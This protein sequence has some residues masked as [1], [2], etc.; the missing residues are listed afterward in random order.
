MQDARTGKTK[1]RVTPFNVKREH[2]DL[3]KR[4]FTVEDLSL[5]ISICTVY[6]VHL[7]PEEMI[8]KSNPFNQQP[9]EETQT[10]SH[11]DLTRLRF[12]HLAFPSDAFV[13]PYHDPNDIILTLSE[14]NLMYIGISSAHQLLTQDDWYPGSSQKWSH[15]EADQWSQIHTLGFYWWGKGAI[16][17]KWMDK[18]GSENSTLR[19]SIIAWIGSPRSKFLI[20]LHINRSR[21]GEA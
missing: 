10:K 11:F 14:K 13:S 6:L 16:P 7:Y 4:D 5:K 21:P 19:W 15:L 8:L 17:N 2:G 1:V 9:R 12:I 20:E 3:A 18:E